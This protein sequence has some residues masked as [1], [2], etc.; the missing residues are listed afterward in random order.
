MG[1]QSRAFSDVY[2]VVECHLDDTDLNIKCLRIN[3]PLHCYLI[4]YFCNTICCFSNVI[5]Q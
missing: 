5:K 1:L 4:N 2:S 3:C